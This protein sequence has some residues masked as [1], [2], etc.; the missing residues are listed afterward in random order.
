MFDKVVLFLFSFVGNNLFI[1]IYLSSRFLKLVN[2][3]RSWWYVQEIWKKNFERVN[4]DI[5]C[6]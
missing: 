3:I 5:K 6:V 4:L 2:I 1:I